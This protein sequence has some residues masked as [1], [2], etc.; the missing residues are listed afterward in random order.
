MN[1]AVCLLPGEPVG[2]ARQWICLKGVP[3]WARALA[4][5]SAG[6]IAAKRLHCYM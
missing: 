1:A 2:H 6:V 4:S 3:K 5:V